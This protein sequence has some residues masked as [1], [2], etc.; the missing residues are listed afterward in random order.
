MSTDAQ[1]TQRQRN[2]CTTAVIVK[3]HEINRAKLTQQIDDSVSWAI[4]CI[5]AI[6]AGHRS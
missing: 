5:R 2:D 3:Y 6:V 1:K 4:A